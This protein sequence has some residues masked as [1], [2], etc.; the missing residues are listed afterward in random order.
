MSGQRARS[1]S[2]LLTIAA[3]WFVF[4]SLSSVSY[5]EGRQRIVDAFAADQADVLHTT[6]TVDR[7]WFEKHQHSSASTS[8]EVTWDSGKGSDFINLSDSSDVRSQAPVG[9][10]LPVEVWRGH[11]MRFELADEWHSTDEEPTVVLDDWR[12]LICVFTAGA[13]VCGRISAHRWLGD[14][15]NHER[16]LAGDLLVL[17]SVVATIIVAATSHLMLLTYLVPFTIGA[18]L[19]SALALPALPW[20]RAPSKPRVPAPPEPDPG[21]AN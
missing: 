16:F 17:L 2:V 4:A 3:L 12:V 7:L 18:L 15:V 13:A 11:V 21:P 6:A 1:I 8:A 14:H 10:R 20:M 5:V 9:Y 19:V